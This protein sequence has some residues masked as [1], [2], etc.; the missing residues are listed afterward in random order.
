MIENENAELE[1]I[2]RVVAELGEHYD[3]VQVFATR[4]EAGTLDG[5]INVQFG[6]GNWFARY[7]QV[8]RWL[9][10]Q[11]EIER[12]EVRRAGDA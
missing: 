6:A 10:K 12:V 2:K 5:T 1:R 9:A 8:A 11:D 7:G 3:T 4:H